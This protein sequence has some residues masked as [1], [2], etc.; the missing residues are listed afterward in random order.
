MTNTLG[1]NMIARFPQ[2]FIFFLLL[3]ILSVELHA[4]DWPSYGGDNGS[5]KYAALDQIGAQ[6]VARLSTAW[7]WD[8]VDNDQVAE[9]RRQENFRA[10]PGG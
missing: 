10:T 4:A 1:G 9:N 8:S 2:K 3:V 5:R 6:N 7:T